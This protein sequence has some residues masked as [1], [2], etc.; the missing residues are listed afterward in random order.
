MREVDEH[1]TLQEQSTA[2]AARPKSGGRR[3]EIVRL[4]SEL[5]REMSYHNATMGKIA[6]IAGI[7]KPTLYHYFRSKEEIL[8]SIH[9]LYITPLIESQRDRVERNVS[10]TRVAYDVIAEHLRFIAESPGVLQSFM[11]NQR[12]LSDER[13][14]EMRT[15]RKLYRHLVE[16]S[17]KRDVEHGV[18]APCDPRLVTFSLFG[19]CNWASRAHSRLTIDEVDDI[20]I[21]L[22]RI[23]AFG[24]HSLHRNDAHPTDF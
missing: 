7:A 5:F 4:S 8:F 13:R 22:W 3:D 18:I 17:F 2:P 9:L 14:S 12:E 10:S 20:A 15:N 16:S 23:F 21:A 24:T 19:V 1:M 11:E 6:D